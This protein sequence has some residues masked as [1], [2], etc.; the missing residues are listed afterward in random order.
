[1]T[2]ISIAKHL[3]QD[4]NGLNFDSPVTHIYNPLDYAWRTHQHYLLDYGQAPKDVLLI[5]MNPGPFGMA[6]T[7]VPFGEISMVRDWLQIE[8]KID[9]PRNPHPKRPVLGFSCQRTEVSGLRFWSWAKERSG[10]AQRFHETFFVWNYCPLVFMEE[11]GRNRTP[12]KLSASEREALFAVCD[13]ALSQVI[14]LFNPS[15]IVGIGRFATARVSQLLGQTQQRQLTNALHPSPAN[16][17]ANRDWAEQFNKAL[18]IAGVPE[19]IFP[20]E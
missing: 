16:P 9:P 11:S 8:E 12:D 15:H 7:G 6:Q 17:M 18:R 13:K 2:L 14:N 3:S 5:G 1:M 19:M 4:V 20:K 10:S